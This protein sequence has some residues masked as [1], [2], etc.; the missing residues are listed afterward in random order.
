MLKP[1][2]VLI[3]LALIVALPVPADA[4]STRLE[5][6]LVKISEV[7]GALHYLRGACYRPERTQWRSEF[8]LLL[9]QYRPSTSLR[10]RMNDAFHGAYVYHQRNYAGCTQDTAY[11]ASK[12]ADDG[13]RLARKLA[14]MFRQ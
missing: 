1:S 12:M 8:D 7:M 14:N 3:A 6:R 9:K 13:E 10:N 5:R 11:R 4:Q 2:V